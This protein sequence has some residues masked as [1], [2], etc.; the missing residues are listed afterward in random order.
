VG[1]LNLRDCVNDLERTGQLVRIEREVDP[2]LEAA[3]I[4]RRVYKV[5]GPAVFYA[6]VKG[7]PFPMVSNLFGTPKRLRFLF[8]DTIEA[9]E[10]LIEL[11]TKP[12]GLRKN[13][14]RYAGVP[15]AIWHTRPKLVNH[16]PI[17]QRRMETVAILPQLQC[18]PRDAGAFAT[19][20]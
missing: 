19:L 5:G 12:A 17:L 13:L 14:L 4:H 9:F 10:R 2:H 1:Y 6:H 3:A 11:K 16:G 7:T 18:W 15:Q 20:T 8:R